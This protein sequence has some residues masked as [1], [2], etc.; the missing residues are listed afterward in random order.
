MLKKYISIFPVYF[1]SSIPFL[2][3]T[4]PFLPDLISVLLG[5]FF[6]YLCSKKNSWKYYFYNKVVVVIILINCILIS[7]SLFSEYRQY[8]LSTSLFYFRHLLFALAI[9]FILKNYK[10]A[11]NYFNFTLYV[12]LFIGSIDCYIQFITGKNIIGMTSYNAYRLGSF[13]GD[14]LIIGSYLARLFPFFLAIIID[15]SR[16]E[17]YKILDFFTFV[18]IA[19]AIY[20]TGERTSFAFCALSILF[21]FVLN[22]NKIF[23]IK[24][25]I[26]LTVLIISLNI[27]FPKIYSKQIEHTKYQFTQE[28][29]LT[30][31]SSE[32]ESLYKS[33]FKMFLDKPLL[34]QGPRTYRLLCNQDNFSV[35]KDYAQSCSTHPH[36]TYFQLLAETG[37]I[38][39]LIILFIFFFISYILIQIIL[40]KNKEKKDKNDIKN[41]FYL[42]AMFINFFPFLPSGNFFNNWLNILYYLPVGFIFYGYSNRLFTK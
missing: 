21:F 7:S 11:L 5:I 6:L 40:G 33:A 17:K 18:L 41:Y 34:G 19:S 3:F 14:E 39:F 22:V 4:G 42:V 20:L 9:F 27:F 36:N 38:F 15:P 24:L 13:F 37:L 16:H 1:F 23:S 28:K 10:N 29:R 32:H 31:F 2:L 30:L 35:K 25:I 12:C 26:S 8:S